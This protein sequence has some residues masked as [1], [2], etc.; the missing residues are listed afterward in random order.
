MVP[1]QVVLEQF[2]RAKDECK[3]PSNLAAWAPML[4]QF[5]PELIIRCEHVSA[6]STHLVEKWLKQY[7]FDGRDNAAELISGIPA[8]LANHTVHKTHHRHIPRD[9]LRAQRLVI[10]SLE[11]DQVFQ[12]LTLSVYHAVTHTFTHT[13]CL[14]IIENQLGRAFIKL[15]PGAMR[16]VTPQPSAVFPAGGTPLSSKM[17]L[18]QRLRLALRV[19]YGR[20]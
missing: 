6:L 15:G 5:G 2:A 17:P 4:A 13:G 10:D 19:L 14:K 16:A 7:M 1:A 12:D 18:L 8:W 20:D 11:D 3:T 9:A